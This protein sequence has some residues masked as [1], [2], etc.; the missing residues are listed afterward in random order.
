MVI[1]LRRTNHHRLLV[2]DL[3]G[4]NSLALEDRFNRELAVFLEGG[5]QL[6]GSFILDVLIVGEKLSR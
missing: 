2:P 4:N 3:A 5:E 6:Y 1:R